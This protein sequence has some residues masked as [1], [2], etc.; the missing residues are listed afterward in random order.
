MKERFGVD[1]QFP[2]SRYVDGF[3]RSKVPDRAGEYPPG[4]TA[5]VGEASCT[6]PL[7]AASLPASSAEELCDLPRGPRSRELVMFAVLG[8]VPGR[9]VDNGPD[10]RAILGADPDNYDYAGQDFH[11]LPSI[12]PR[13]TLPPPSAT[14]GD[15]GTDP[16]HGREWDTRGDDLQYACTFE[17]PTPRSCTAVDASCDC[18][19]VEKNPPL[20][21]TQPGEQLSAKAYPTLRPLRVA[22]GLG[23]RAVVRSICPGDPKAGYAPAMDAFASR[24]APKLAR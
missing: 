19:L 24:V 10:W 9:L 20:C 22:K 21:G 12:A 14:R 13:P 3:T 5:Y 15:N 7:F 16:D 17:L 23:D 4:A 6:N 8:G 1:P 2:I 18:A 11:M